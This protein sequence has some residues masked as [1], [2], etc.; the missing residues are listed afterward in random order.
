MHHLWYNSYILVPTLIW[1]AR[2]TA[3]AVVFLCM[4]AYELLKKVYAASEGDTDYPSFE[5][6]D[7]QLY[8]AHLLTALNKWVDEFPDL[9]E[10]Y[11][12]LL[13][14]PDGD[15]V[16]VAGQTHYSLPSNF[17]S[18]IN[19]IIVGGSTLD[20]LPPE[21]MRQNKDTAWYSLLGY[22]G[23][24]TLIL[25][26]I[27]AG[28]QLIDFSYYKTITKPT[29]ASSV[30]EISRPYYCYHYIMYQLYKDDVNNKDIAREAKNGMQEEIIKEKV[31]R[32]KSPT[33]TSI[34]MRGSGF[35]V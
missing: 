4:T 18:F 33:G 26:P 34:S 7:M 27:P 25:N 2:T 9:G 21:K 16:T 8:F 15:K 5:D 24:Y 32:M 23:A 19:P 14:S 31:A 29:T 12:E 6:E 35:G 10:T 28:G 13:D 30:I 11:A 20:F 3:F 17:V 1:R 22:P